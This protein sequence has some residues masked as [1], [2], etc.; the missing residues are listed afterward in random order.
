MRNVLHWESL[1]ASASNRWPEVP[2]PLILAVIAAESGGNPRAR[3]RAGAIGLMQIIPRSW[4][5][6][7]AE[8]FDPNYNVR[9]GTW[10]LSLSLQLADGDLRTALAYYNCGPARVEADRCG[11]Y[12]G[13]IYADDVLDHWVPLFENALIVEQ[14]DVSGNAR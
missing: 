7:E 6:T 3:S 12:G 5:G 9:A 13:Y 2:Q 4:I 1:A 8:L 10:H 11:T 14:D